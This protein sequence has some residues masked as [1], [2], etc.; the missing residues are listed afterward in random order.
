M[1]VRKVQGDS[2]Q[3]FENDTPVLT[4]EEPDAD[5]GVMMILKGALKSEFADHIQDELDAYTTIGIKVLIDFKEATFV[6]AALLKALLN[7]QQL[8]DYFRNNQI[9]LKNIPH[10]VY[11]EMD[12]SGISELLMIET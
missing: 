10:A 2:I 7:S 8:V 1:I 6:S 5:D 4:I 9:V 12:K 3:F 11:R